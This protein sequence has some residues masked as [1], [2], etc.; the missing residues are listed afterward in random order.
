MAESVGDNEIDTKVQKWLELDKNNVTRAQVV[1]LVEQKNISHLRSIMC[2]KM[3]FGT[4]GIRGAMEAGFGRMNDLTIIQITQ[5][6]CKY[7]LKSCPNVKEN[8]VVIGFDGRHNSK[9]F[10]E[11]TAGIF[12]HAG[13]RV[14]LFS[15]MCPTPYVAYSVS[16]LHCDWGIMITASHNPKQDNGYKVYGQNGAQIIAPHDKEI[17][18]CIDESFEPLPTSWDTSIVQTSELCT[19]PFETVHKNYM[20]DLSKLCHHKSLNE[21]TTHAFIYTPMH[22]VGSRYVQAAA[23]VFGVP[24]IYEVTEQVVP[25]GDFPT[26]PFPNPEE[27]GTLNLAIEYSYLVGATII[28]ATDPDADRFTMAERQSG[29]YWIKF[30]G[31]ELGALLGWWIWQKERHKY[32]EG[33]SLYML[34]STVSSKILRTMAKAEGFLFEET[35]TGFKWM[36]NKAFS[37]KQQDSRNVVLFAFEEA[38]GFMCGSSVLDKDGVSACMI[39]TEMCIWLYSQ[40]LSLLEQLQSIYKQYGYHLSKNSY[41]IC[42]E[43]D[44]IRAIFERLRNYEDSGTYPKSCGKY[45]IK[46]VRDLTTGYDNSMPDNKAALPT[47][48]S[49][50]MITFTFENGSVA[51]LRTSGTEP[52][53]KYYTEFIAPKDMDRS[54]ANQELQ[55]LVENLINLFLEPTKHGIKAP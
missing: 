36:G 18:S 1:S 16:N 5:G 41:F 33:S 11:L 9:R 49:S 31:N 23:K 26:L 45:A 37:L 44:K 20:E 15:I 8:G 21:A 7:A 14:H 6:L 38:I 22:G 39:A 35:L 54:D 2:S 47:S 24:N 42:H 12:L 34:S 46:Y 17:A 10:A 43:P 48:K 40:R 30:S 3:D 50:Q 29:N 55:Q 32:P 13:I 4:A 28:L 53:I 27:E 51:T 19:D 25:D 52:K